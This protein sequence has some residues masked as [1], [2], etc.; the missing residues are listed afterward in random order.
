MEVGEE[1]AGGTVLSCSCSAVVLKV[2]TTTH[3]LAQILLNYG[4]KQLWY[5]TKM[6]IDN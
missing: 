6:V 1:A 2:Y 5:K 4:F 3:E